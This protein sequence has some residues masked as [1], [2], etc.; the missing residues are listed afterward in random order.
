MTLVRI[1][2][3][4]VMGIPTMSDA[5]ELPASWQH[6]DVFPVIAR[7]ISEIHESKSDFVTHDEITH[8][9]LKDAESAAIIEHARAQTKEPHTDEWLA[10]NM[11]AWFSQRITVGDSDWAGRLERIKI[12]GKWA[13]RPRSAKSG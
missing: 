2:P 10:H 5:S 9:L 1:K 12:D 4:S 11:V 7:I 3:R 8:R 6:A 13:Y